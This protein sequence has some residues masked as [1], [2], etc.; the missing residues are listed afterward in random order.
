MQSVP[1]TKVGKVYYFYMYMYITKHSLLT[2]SSLNLHVEW[3]TILSTTHVVADILLMALSHC[4][5]DVFETFDPVCQIFEIV[6]LALK[7][8]AP[9]SDKRSV[10]ALHQVELLV[11]NVR[12]SVGA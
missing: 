2:F 5:R 1:A 7:A 6:M 9:K 11:L 8:H 3:T 4:L 10:P 12:K